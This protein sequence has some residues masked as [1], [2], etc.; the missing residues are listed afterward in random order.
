MNMFARLIFATAMFLTV[1]VG[2]AL[3]CEID[4]KT[5]KTDYKV[6]DTVIFKVV[7]D[8]QH[9]P[10]RKEAEEPTITLKED[11][12]ALVGKTK[13]KKVTDSQWTISYKA[14]LKSKK[15]TFAAQRHCPDGGSNKSITIDA[16]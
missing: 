1:G 9:K 10:C 13:M 6:G 5:D 2:T 11:E 3:A 4:I 7:I 16:K 15:A 12:L 14:T 8:Q